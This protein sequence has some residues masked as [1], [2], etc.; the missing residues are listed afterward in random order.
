M[1][2]VPCINANSKYYVV[3]QSRSHVQLCDPVDC[4]T[5]GFPVLHYL[6]EFAQTH[7][8]WV[9]DA[10][11]PYHPLSSPSAFN[12]SQ[13]QNLSQWVSSLHQVAKVLELPFQ[14]LS[15]QWILRIDFLYDWLVW[16]PWGSRDSQESSPAPS[17]KASILQ[18]SA[19]FIVQVSYLY[20]TAGKAIA[21]TLQTFVSK[22]MSLLFHKLSRFVIAML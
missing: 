15:F 11:Q 2:L 10:I 6:L 14:Y 17:S 16:S 20:M 4:S 22:V 1:Y 5:P 13:H 21:L 18:H 12:L 3:V 19:F 8:H 7:G 9:D